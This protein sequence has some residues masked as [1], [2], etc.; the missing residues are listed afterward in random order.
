M[1]SSQNINIKI[2]VGKWHNIYGTLL[3]AQIFTV[4]P[5][6]DYVKEIR[7]HGADGSLNSSSYTVIQEIPHS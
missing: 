7:V 4:K 6:T 5:L 3:S 2:F 1:H